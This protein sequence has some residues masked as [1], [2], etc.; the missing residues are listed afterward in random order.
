[1][2]KDTKDKPKPSKEEQMRTQ[3]RLFAGMAKTKLYPIDM[4]PLK[5]ARNEKPDPLPVDED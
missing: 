4:Q 2:T 3:Q 5:T 1:M